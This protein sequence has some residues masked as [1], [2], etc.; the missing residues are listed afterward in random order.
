MR[1]AKWPGFLSKKIYSGRSLFQKTRTE[2]YSYLETESTLFDDDC[3]VVM[4]CKEGEK[5]LMPDHINDHFAT[6]H[7]LKGSLQEAQATF[8]NVKNKSI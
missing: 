5:K 2:E 1:W 8:T 4:N 3:E 7:Y 6:F